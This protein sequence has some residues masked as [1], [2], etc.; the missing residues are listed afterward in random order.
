MPD[1]VSFGLGI[2]FAGI[3]ANILIN[4]ND[5]NFLYCIRI[6]STFVYWY[7]YYI[8]FN[9]SGAYCK[10][11]TIIEVGRKS[12]GKTEVNTIHPL[13]D[14]TQKQLEGKFTTVYRVPAE[15]ANPRIVSDVPKETQAG[16]VSSPQVKNNIAKS[17]TK[18]KISNL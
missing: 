17:A 6:I 11:R 9:I 12:S 2:R 18:V 8:N 5:T 1:N 7:R 14:K 16:G 15:T 3:D 4:T 13:G 10:T